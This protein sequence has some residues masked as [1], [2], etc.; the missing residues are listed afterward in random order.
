LM[1]NQPKDHLNSLMRFVEVQ[2]FF[3]NVSNEINSTWL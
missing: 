1:L 2:D 3:H